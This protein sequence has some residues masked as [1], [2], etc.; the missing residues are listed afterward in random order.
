[1]KGA[2]VRVTRL[3]HLVITT[4]D[5]DR[6]ADFY[7]RVCGMEIHH[8]GP[9]NRVALRFGEQKIN[10]HRVGHEFHPCAERPGA[11]TQDL[12]FVVDVPPEEVRAHL[13]ACGVEIEQGPVA[14]TGALGPI[15]SHYFRDPDGNLVELAS[16]DSGEPPGV[17]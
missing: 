11:G 17:S 2:T 15:M 4:T 8:F 5:I 6:T 14:R 10:L 16:Y 1:M 7:A 12:C 13:L 9:D 3:D